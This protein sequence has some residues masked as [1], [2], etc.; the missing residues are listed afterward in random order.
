[1]VT[2]P[3][4]HRLIA[5]LYAVLER[6]L[7]IQTQ[8]IEAVV[9]DDMNAASEFDGKLMMARKQREDLQKQLFTHVDEHR[10]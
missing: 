7:S 2:C 8:K 5:E 4:K 3:E 6:I 9:H 10:C 1:M